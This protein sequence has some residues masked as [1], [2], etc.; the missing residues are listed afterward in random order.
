MAFNPD[1]ALS[2]RSGTK[3]GNNSQNVKYISTDSLWGPKSM[4]NDS[5]M[6]SRIWDNKNPFLTITARKGNLNNHMLHSIYEEHIPYCKGRKYLFKSG[7]SVARKFDACEC[8]SSRLLQRNVGH[9]G[10]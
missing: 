8:V 6:P 1:W 4:L 10:A 3:I 2:Q 7:Q 9:Y 5:W